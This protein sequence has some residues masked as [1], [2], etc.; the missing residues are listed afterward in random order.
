MMPKARWQRI[1]S[2]FGELVDSGTGDREARLARACGDDAELRRSVESLLESDKTSQ[3]PLQHVIGEAAEALLHDH[4]DRLIGTHVGR[5]RIVAIL[6]RGGMSTVYRAERDE[7]QYHQTVAIKVLQQAALH[8]RMHSRLHGEKHILASLDH[9]SIARLIDSGDLDDGT[10]YLVMEHVDGESI[11][12]YCDRRNLPVRQRLEL[13]VQVCAAVQYAHRNLVVHRDIKPSNILVTEEGVPKL[14]DFGIAKLLAPENASHTL[15]VTLLQD[16]IL[17]PENAAP[18]QVLG[19][20]IT[21]ATDIYAL[22]VLLYQLLTGRSPYRLITFSQLQLERAIC[23]DEPTRPSQVVIAKLGAEKDADRARISGRLGLTPQRLRAQLAGDLD[24]VI[25]MAMRKEPDRRY[26]SIETFADDINRHLMGEPVRACQGDWRYKGAKF[27]RRNVWGVAIV[28]VVTVGLAVIAGVLFWNNLRVKAMANEI[29][30]QRD[31]A[32]QVSAFLVDVFSRADPFTAQ[33]REETAKDVLD[34]GAAKISVDSSLQP[35]VRAELLESIGV[36]Y[37][38]QGMS[39]AAIPLFEQAVEI[40]RHAQPPDNGRTAVALGNLARAL[41]DD[42]NMVSADADLQEAVELSQAGGA[43]TAQTADI[44]VELGNFEINAKSDPVRAEALF[45]KALA[46]YRG[47]P[48]DQNLNIAAA[49]DSLANAAMWRADYARAEPFARE[50][51]RIMQ[52]AVPRK[53]PENASALQMLGAILVERQNYHEAEQALNEALDIERSVFGP[54]NSRVAVTLAELGTLHD[55][56]DNVERAI[57]ETREAVKIVRATRET[58][59]YGVAYYLDALANMYLKKGDLATA[60]ADARE[61]LSIYA[62]SSLPPH[63]LYVASTHQVLGEILLARDQPA[64]AETEFRTAY[65]INAELAPQSWWTARSQA[66]LGWTLIQ[67]GDAEQGE[68]LLVAART[69]LLAEVGTRHPAAKQATAR[70]VDYY[71]SRHRDADAARILA[72]P[73]KG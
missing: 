6:G 17:T 12:D 37:R 23:M 7:A 59:F 3:D 2:L 19:R 71:R 50:S 9:P 25:S 29:A 70:L 16:R 26:A 66:S 61:S 28:G 64:A 39:K 72:A 18:E 10:P 38:R 20:P 68:P 48:G 54:E 44:L 65:D 40:R 45:G 27:L 69:K 57:E 55:R 5:Y 36:A 32:R 46:L 21:T 24:A 22:G 30:A 31:I 14:L 53:H 47:A 67:R 13:F 49:L 56:Q 1:Q 34:R 11:D 43:Q 15:P 42:G 73:D 35:E 63:H 8:P 33:G 60:E 4:N 51:V 58:N 62:R 41:E 52:R